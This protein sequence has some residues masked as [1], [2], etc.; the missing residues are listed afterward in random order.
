MDW[1]LSGKPRAVQLE[2]NKRSYPRPTYAYFME[3]RLGKTAAV[4]NEYLLFQRDYNVRRL[5]VFAPSKYKWGWE[6][7]I[8]KFGMIEKVLVFESGNQGRN[9]LRNYDGD[10]V[11]VNYEALIYEDNVK[12]LARFRPDMVVADESVM[13]KNRNT[14][15]FKNSRMIADQ[16][17]VVRI[18]T[19]K[20]VVQGAHDL[21]SQ[22]R[23]IRH[24]DSVNFYAFRNT[25]CKMGG[26]M[27]KQVVGM[28]NYERLNEILSLCSFRAERKEWGGYFETD[29]E[30]R[31]LEILPEQKKHYDE[32]D[33]EFITWLQ[34]GMPVTADQVMTKHVKL[35]QISSGFIIDIEKKT[36]DI[37]PLNKLPKLLD[38]KESLTN[39]V[40][41]KALVICYYVYSLERLLQ[42]LKE[43]NPALIAGALMMKRL[44][45]NVESEKEKFNTDPT[46]RIVLAQVQA[47]KFGHN[48]MG[49]PED[50]CGDIFYYENNYNLDDRAQS[51]QRPQGFGQKGGVHVIDYAT[52]KVEKKIIAAL[53]RK[54]SVSAAILSAYQ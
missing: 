21:W 26:F 3:M 27:G 23:F 48:L 18:L 19:G 22:L 45:R 43:F 53:Q 36:H 52:T 13:I 9:Q 34:S 7:E 1:L 50:P 38:I 54:E 15:F 2:A 17:K 51:E 44:G 46:C 4:L 8:K 31:A 40:S 28:Q 16:A 47:V 30:T 20:P 5:M 14:T 29:Y 49:P 12:L 24:L 41:H 6:A 33:E 11:I 37:V 35:Q 32:M 39:E 42:E 25:Y 10:I